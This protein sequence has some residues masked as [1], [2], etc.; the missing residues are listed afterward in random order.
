[1][2]DQLPVRQEPLVASQLRHVCQER[3][4]LECMRVP[5][6]AHG[7]SEV[8]DD[9]MRARDTRARRTLAARRPLLTF[10]A[11]EWLA[12]TKRQH[13]EFWWV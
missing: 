9:T 3:D 10:E 7:R 13:P 12:R 5:L 11:G 1:M 8:L 4:E 6:Q 2:R